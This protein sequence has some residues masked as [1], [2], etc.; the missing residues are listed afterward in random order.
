MENLFH[1]KK[2][3]IYKL[4]IIKQQGQ[5]VYYYVLNEYKDKQSL[6]LYKEIKN[7]KEC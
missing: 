5:K 4:I 2:I 7:I 1:E 6:L 3:G